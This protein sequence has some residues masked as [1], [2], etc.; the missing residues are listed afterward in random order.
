MWDGDDN[1]FDACGTWFDDCLRCVPQRPPGCALPWRGKRCVDAHWHSRVT[2]AQV[3]EFTRRNAMRIAHDDH[4]R[5][6]LCKLNRVRLG[7]CPAGPH[8]SCDDD[9]AQFRKAMV[10]AEYYVRTRDGID[11]ETAGGVQ[12]LAKIMGDLGWVP[13]SIVPARPGRMII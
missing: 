11:V 4:L 3:E 8:P 13:R 6:L 1:G 5:A 10:V 2:D 7:P 9:D 12:A